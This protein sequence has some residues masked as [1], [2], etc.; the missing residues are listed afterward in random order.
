M[1][2]S[3]RRWTGSDAVVTASFLA[4]V[5]FMA[6]G[7]FPFL[8]IAHALGVALFLFE[9]RRVD[10][11]WLALAWV[12]GL[13]TL[14]LGIHGAIHGEWR[15][16]GYGAYLFSAAGISLTMHRRGLPEVV[17]WAL[18]VVFAAFV[19]VRLAAG[20]MPN[21]VLPLRSRNH[22]SVIALGIALLINVLQVRDGR[23][24]SLAPAVVAL[25][26]SVLGVGRAGII[27]GAVYL[28]GT[29]ALRLDVLIPSA[30]RW[31][32]A[33]GL[34]G[35]LAA[36]AVAAGPATTALGTVHQ[37]EFQQRGL[38]S[39]VRVDVTRRYLEHLDP[40]TLLVGHS[41]RFLDSFAFT[42]HNSYLLWHQLFGVG[43]LFLAC[44]VLVVLVRS[45]T[46]HPMLTVAT[47]VILLRSITD[48]VLVPGVYFDP[49]LAL[50]GLTV[51][52]TPGPERSGDS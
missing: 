18:L 12:G 5:A 19:V 37:I 4:A 35:V 24:P 50:I 1:G 23:R 47:A 44:V 22:I 48:T 30:R 52:A 40:V 51:L 10:G 11:P 25:G 45:P 8:R 46:V 39:Q 13:L 16:L 33:A 15:V 32:V 34:A 17:P 26:V 3:R 27:T 38:E 31:A 9:A 36:A 49:V 6:T 42:L 2:P 7:L 28:A 20:N 29:L 43:A 21:E 41:D 14:C